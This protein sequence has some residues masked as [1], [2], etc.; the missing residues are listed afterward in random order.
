MGSM[1]A[2]SLAAPALG[3]ERGPLVIAAS[4]AFF[5]ASLLRRQET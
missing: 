5:F 1:L 3:V 4:A 2:G